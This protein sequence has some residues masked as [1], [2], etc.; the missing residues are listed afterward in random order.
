M[1]N[2]IIRNA[3]LADAEAIVLCIDA[4]YSKYASQVPG[5]PNVSEGVAHEITHNQVWVAVQQGEIIAGLFLVSE[6]GFMKLANVAVHPMH[7][8]KGVERS[9]VFSR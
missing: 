4:A 2:L 9:C 5:L 8:S 3:R 1:E 6:D 7:G